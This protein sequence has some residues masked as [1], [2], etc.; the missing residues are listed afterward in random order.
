[1][2]HE[3]PLNVKI[4]FFRAKGNKTLFLSLKTADTF[5]YRW[6]AEI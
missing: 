3:S 2:M 4:W 5:Q 6:T 1:M